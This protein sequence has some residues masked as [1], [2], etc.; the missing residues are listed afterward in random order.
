MRT[1][2]TA[3][4]FSA[5]LGTQTLAAEAPAGGAWTD[6]S[7]VSVAAFRDYVLVTCAEAPGAGLKGAGVANGTPREF[8]IESMIPLTDP[9]LRLSMV[10]KSG[11]RPLGILFVKDAVA[12]PP[13]CLLERCRRIAG[14]ELK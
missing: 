4:I 3:L 10:A 14:V 8:G 12:N 11:G 2:L 7:V 1:V 9:V 6:C 5:G 13:G